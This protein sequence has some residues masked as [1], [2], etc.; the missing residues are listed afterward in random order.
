MTLS[1]WHLEKTKY[2]YS[3][4]DVHGTLEP[5]A[6]AI[7][8]RG[9]YSKDRFRD[10]EVGVA[11]LCPTKHQAVGRRFYSAFQ[12]E[13]W[14]YKPFHEAYRLR[15]CHYHPMRVFGLDADPAAAYRSVAEELIREIEE[16][17]VDLWICLVLIED[18][19]KQL[20][21]RDNPYFVCRGVLLSNRILVQSVTVEKACQ[22]DSKLR[23]ILDSV[24]VQSYAK[25]GGTP[26]V[27]TAER[28]DPEIVIGIGEARPLTMQR[29][30]RFFGFANIFNQNGA[31]LWTRFG[32][33]VVGFDAY[34][35]SLEGKIKQSIEDYTQ[36]ERVEPKRLIIHLY[37][38]PGKRTEARAIEDALS[39]LDLGIEYAI[40]H[41]DH[42]T[43]F[44]ALDTEDGGLKPEGRL[45]VYVD[46]Y[47]RLVVLSGREVDWIPPRMARL[48]LA[49]QSTYR[50]LNSLT[51]QVYDFTNV[52]WAGFQPNNVPVTIKYPALLA[53]K[54]ASLE[55]L[56]EDWFGRITETF[57]LDKV[58]FI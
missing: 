44:R 25:I 54:Y 23:W 22:D 28:S 16:T 29:N 41:I 11:M 15:S 32:Q 48:R 39:D 13:L 20:L 35:A 57:L 12:Q 53:Q 6:K 30:A 36:I 45:V 58:W 34:I 9:P 24:A 17:S 49:P 40:V 47:Q 3:Y 10:L 14:P 42:N 2:K 18:R 21:V 5:P 37:K 19:Y 56:G 4:E 46:D 8:K 50:D 27:V 38:P 52:N 51:Q 33:P 43:D 31:Y 55:Q 1:A 26:W 7:K